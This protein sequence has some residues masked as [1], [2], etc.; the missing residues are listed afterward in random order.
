MARI[1]NVEKS[2]KDIVT[3]KFTN[4]GA[5][6]KV[7]KPNRR[8]WFMTQ[9]EQTKFRVNITEDNKGQYFDIVVSDDVVLNV[10]NVRKDIKHILLMFKEGRDKTKIL[11]GHDEREWFTSQVR[12]RSK[13]VAEA[14]EFLK[15]KEVVL[16]QKKS[17]VKRKDINKRRNKGFIRQGEWFFVPE[18]IEIDNEFVLRNE[19]LI[20]S[21]T[22]AG[23]KPHISQY[24][25]RT[26]G[27]T[28]YVP[29]AGKWRPSDFEGTWSSQ[30]I[31]GLTENSKRS[32]LDRYPN[33]NVQFR[34]MTR[35]PNLYVTG[36]VRHPDH[37]TINL[38]GWHRVYVNEEIRGKNVAFLD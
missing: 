19:P 10:I 30:L 17:K 1:Y 16:S 35:N 20:L 5:R 2:K 36:T 3:E 38:I 27:E 15:P 28:V 7:R 34:M 4:I 14:M 6:V 12:T 37:K 24:A 22:R 13:D 11:C 8:D 33:S 21:G 9:R 26:G 18:E 31:R 25:Y 29:M 32:F 23:N